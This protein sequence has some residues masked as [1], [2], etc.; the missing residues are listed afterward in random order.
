VGL[1]NLNIAS[2]R[3]MNHDMRRFPL[4]LRDIPLRQHKKEH[5]AGMGHPSPLDLYS[6]LPLLEFVHEANDFSDRSS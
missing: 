1:S 4:L 2:L 6:Q 3:E 5:G